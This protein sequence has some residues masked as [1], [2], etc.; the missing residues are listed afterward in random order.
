[1]PPDLVV[2]KASKSR[3]AFSGSMPTPESSTATRPGRLVQSRPDHQ[4]ARPVGDRRHGLNA[5]DDQI[6]DHL[7]QLHAVAEHR[8]QRRRQSSRSDTRWLNTSC[9]TSGSPR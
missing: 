2:K 7:L 3:S 4:F 1:M 8:R 5:V 6:D 9:C